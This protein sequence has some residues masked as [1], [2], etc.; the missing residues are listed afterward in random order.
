MF[1]AICISQLAQSSESTQSNVPFTLVTEMLKTI[2]QSKT[3]IKSLQK[4]LLLSEA[5]SK[6]IQAE[7][8]KTSAESAVAI[9]T[10]SF[11]RRNEMVMDYLSRYTATEQPMLRAKFAQILTHTCA[12]PDCCNPDKQ[13]AYQYRQRYLLRQMQSIERQHER[14]KLKFTKLSSQ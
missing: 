10:R 2:K 5:D 13:E 4:E 14:F 6:K 11:D 7:K 1:I 9:L 8:S 12:D 3:I